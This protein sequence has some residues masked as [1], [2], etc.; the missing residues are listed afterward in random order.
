MTQWSIKQDIDGIPYL[1]DFMIEVEKDAIVE[2]ELTRLQMKVAD[3]WVDVNYRDKE[4][5][6]WAHDIMTNQENINQIV[7]DSKLDKSDQY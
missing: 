2:W 5:G 6:F 4:S 3:I 7:E 1:F